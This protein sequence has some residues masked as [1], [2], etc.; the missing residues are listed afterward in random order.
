MADVAEPVAE[1]A[2]II[3]RCFEALA[4]ASGKTL[5]T[6]MRVD[7]VRACELLANPR[8]ELD[9]LLEDLLSVPA[10]PRAVPRDRTTVAFE[11]EPENVPH[12]RQRARERMEEQ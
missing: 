5:S 1:A 11:R 6:R 3:T 7:L 8:E 4:R 2:A 10:T 12:W 9:D